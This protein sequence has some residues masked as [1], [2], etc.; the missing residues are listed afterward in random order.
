MSNPIPIM[1]LNSIRVDK[2]MFVKD[3]ESDYRA[4][5]TMNGE[6]GSITVNLNAQETVAIVAAVA[7]ALANAGES[8]AKRLRDSVLA[9]VK[10]LSC[11]VKP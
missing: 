1:T 4:S 3:G 11:E 7:D 9:S 5:I 2:R 6:E 10:T 8:A